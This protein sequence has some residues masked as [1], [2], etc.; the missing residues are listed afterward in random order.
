MNIVPKFIAIE[1]VKTIT[2]SITS[3]T[4]TAADVFERLKILGQF[5]ASFLKSLSPVAA[6]VVTVTTKVVKVISSI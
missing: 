3:V 5:S 4:G 1:D 6:L 2:D